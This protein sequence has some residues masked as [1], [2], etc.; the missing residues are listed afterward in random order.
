[1]PK[2]AHAL[3]DLRL[4][5]GILGQRGLGDWWDTDFLTPTGRQLLEYNFPRHPLLAGFSATCEA[6]QR[7]HDDRIGRRNTYHLFRLPAERE[8]EIHRI[9]AAD[10]GQR[11]R[12]ID[13]TREAAMAVLERLAAESV[14]APEGPVQ[15][16][17]FRDV[18]RTRGVE[19]MAKHYLSALRRGT[20]SLPYFAS[21]SR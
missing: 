5:V 19:E 14:D 18:N 4:A 3:C 8:M 9:A 10:G 2:L 15:V 16:G 1:M 7:L 11:L 20:V 17:D 21:R 6:A 13:P 12:T